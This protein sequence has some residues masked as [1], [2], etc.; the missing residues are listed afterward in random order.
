MVEKDLPEKALCISEQT[1]WSP[2]LMATGVIVMVAVGLFL[3]L[4]IRQ[5]P[6]L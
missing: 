2:F 4:A 3:F 6:L 1:T 5:R